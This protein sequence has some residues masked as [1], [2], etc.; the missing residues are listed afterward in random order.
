RDFLPQ[1][2]ISYFEGREGVF[3]MIDLTLLQDTPL[4]FISA[5]DL[6]PQ[7]K[8]Y[9]QKVYAS[10]RRLMKSKSQMLVTLTGASESYIHDHRDLYDWIGE[11]T[12]HDYRLESTIIIFDDKIQF[13][14]TNGP[15]MGGVM[16]E[17]AYL[18]RTMKA[19][20]RLL[21]NTVKITV[22]KKED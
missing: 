15:S 18:S 17:N 4:Y 6:D 21:K 12:T 9:I 5:H 1:S 20:F 10:K 13:I 8:D 19:V 11:I 3:K 22:I 16:I 7:L 14:L 2:K